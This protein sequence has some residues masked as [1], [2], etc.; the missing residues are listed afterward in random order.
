[1]PVLDLRKVF[2]LSWGLRLRAGT[3]DKITV[4]IRDNV[5]GVDQF[6]CIAYGFKRIIQN[7]DN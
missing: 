3:E 2:G 6:D 5:S 7:N 4:T 1:M